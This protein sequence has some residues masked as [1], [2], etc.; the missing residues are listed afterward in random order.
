[1]VVT[2]GAGFIGSHLVEELV[3]RG[4]R[5]IVVDDLSTGVPTNLEAV[6]GSIETESLDLRRDGLAQLFSSTPVQSVFHL[7]GQAGVEASL[8]GA[9]SDMESNVGATLMLLEAVRSAAPEATLLHVS[10]AVVYGDPQDRPFREDDPTAPSTPYAVSKLAAEHYV[11]VFARL[12]GLRAAVLR[13]FS[14]YGPRQR[15]QVVYDLMRRISDDPNELHV[16][17]DGT[18]ERAFTFVSSIV[19]ALVAVADR[20]ELVGEVYNVV[21]DD[22]ASIAELVAMLCERMNV[23]PRV[24]YEGTPRPGDVLRLSGDTT[25]LRSLGWQPRV[26][27]REG[28][29]ETVAWFRRSTGRP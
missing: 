23:T 19:D 22:A 17:G 2:G 4:Q 26:S 21:D 7:A 14:A 16:R 13:P 24:V 3:R 5:V 18:E 9:R 10:S 20:A 12:Y 28:L 15:K 27:L 11:R 8:A 1:M 6:A 29:D 25:R